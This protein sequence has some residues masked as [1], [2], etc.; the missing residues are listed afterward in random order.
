MIGLDPFPLYVMQHEIIKRYA[1]DAPNYVVP[2]SDDCLPK[3]LEAFDVTLSMGVLYHRTSPIDHLQVLCGS[4][5]RGGQLVLETLVVDSDDQTVLVPQG[6]YAKMRN[7]WFIPSVSMLS[8]WLKRTGFRNINIIDV[9]ATTTDEQRG[10][11]W[12]TFESLPDF[13]DPQ[14]ASRTIE[15]YP[16]PLRA[17]L[18]ATK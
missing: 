9:T 4:L 5:K 7:V 6:R 11:D 10:T 12:M 15:G 8:L 18:T 1:S 16:A 14:D 13:L 2:S 3:A 17:I